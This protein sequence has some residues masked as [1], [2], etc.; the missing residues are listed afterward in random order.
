[1]GEQQMA[2]CCVRVGKKISQK[3]HRASK[4][5][6]CLPR[7]KKVVGILLSIGLK[8][9]GREL[10]GQMERENEQRRTWI[11]SLAD[12]SQTVLIR[13]QLMAAFNASTIVRIMKE[14]LALRSFSYRFNFWIE[15]DSFAS[16]C[17]LINLISFFLQ[18]FCKL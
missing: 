4:I 13:R 2:P 5:F 12:V 7:N 16:R 11:H 10:P 1:M 14:W 3:I 17:F 9:T 6:R 15:F 18:I 8:A